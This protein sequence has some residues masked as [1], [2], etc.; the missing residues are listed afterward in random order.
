MMWSMGWAN[1]PVV[2]V[3]CAVLATSVVLEG[4]KVE[5]QERMTEAPSYDSTYASRGI[6][7]DQAAIDRTGTSRQHRKSVS[8][9]QYL[10][11]AL[12]AKKTL[13]ETFSGRTV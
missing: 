10:E 12:E 7:M 13:R 3:T 6:G 1:L 9:H 11:R 5:E 8:H 4:R 2:V